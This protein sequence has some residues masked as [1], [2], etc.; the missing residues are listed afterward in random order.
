MDNQPMDD[1][2][3]S[4]LSA[5]LDHELSPDQRHR[6]ET[7]L[8]TRADL[9]LTLDRLVRVRAAIAACKIELPSD[10][11][12]VRSG[13]W[14]A[15]KL[16]ASPTIESASSSSTS[17]QGKWFLHAPSWLLTVAASLLVIGSLSILYWFPMGNGGNGMIATRM[18]TRSQAPAPEMQE[19]AD[20]AAKEFRSKEIAADPT[21]APT[22][23]APKIPSDSD[24][25]PPPSPMRSEAASSTMSLD[26]SVETLRET[27]PDVLSRND[28]FFSYFL[29][30][31]ESV[32]ILGV[33]ATET[34]D[35]PTLAKR[36]DVWEFQ[37]TSVDRAKDI[38]RSTPSIADRAIVLFQPTT[39]T[40][41]SQANAFQESNLAEWSESSPKASRG[42]E[43]GN[44][45]MIDRSVALSRGMPS[46]V[47]AGS[48]GDKGRE[49]GILELRIPVAYWGEATQSLREKGFEIPETLQ[50]GDY[51]FEPEVNPGNP[52]KPW[53]VRRLGGEP[54]VAKDQTPAYYTLTVILHKPEAKSGSSE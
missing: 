12:I 53:T 3:E 54:A 27:R 1:F 14:D 36:R 31:K 19:K 38:E 10:A 39:G 8:E 16:Q 11:R 15:P 43:D 50:P 41:S 29:G 9:R 21:N 42:L 26:F 32:A 46:S 25:P 40:A 37:W 51:Q 22:G 28:S 7:M 6:V 2:D 20:I 52:A 49:P 44:D 13:P 23:F 30:A 48:D 24:G 45:K 35:L 18:D 17:S 4:W 34:T 47:A 5:Y 33:E